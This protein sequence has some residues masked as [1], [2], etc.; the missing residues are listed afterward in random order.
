MRYYIEIYRIYRKFPMNSQVNT[1]NARRVLK[2]WQIL[3]M[4]A[5]VLGGLIVAAMKG[6]EQA[7]K[8]P[9]VLE[10]SNLTESQANSL[11]TATAPFGRVQF[12]GADLMG[13]HQV[14]SSLSWVESASVKR[15]WQQG[16]IV[17][18]VPRRAVAN[19][20]SQHL[21]D[22]N[23]AVFVPADEHELMDKNLVHLYSGHTND[24]TDMMRQMQRVNEW[25]SPLGITA[26]DMTLTSRQ[27]WLI[28]FDNGLRVIVDHEN[29]EQKLFSL[30]SLLA[31]SLAKELPKIQS[32][33]LRYKNGFAIAWK[34]AGI[35]Q[36][37]SDLGLK[38]S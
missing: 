13:I 24:A 2:L 11:K 32:V 6:I 20:G 38:T 19:F 14:V 7:P 18:V 33:D 37:P 22:A 21:L 36:K 26:E 12:F 28:R 25:F 5:I 23:G 15:D 8:R 1:K 35:P 17:S 29:T 31:G 30:S 3:L 34:T 16:V 27:T 9:L 10:L 4:V